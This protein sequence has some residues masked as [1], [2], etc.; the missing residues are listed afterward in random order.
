[1]PD[2]LNAETSDAGHIMLDGRNLESFLADGVLPQEVLAENFEDNRKIN[3]LL[4]SLR[5]L[6]LAGL[7]TVFGSAA[8]P[9]P[10]DIDVLADLRECTAADWTSAARWP[11]SITADSI[12]SIRSC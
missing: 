7:V 6:P 3:S 5:G 12:R 8:R 11:G 4:D 10:G 9:F 2:R 1:V